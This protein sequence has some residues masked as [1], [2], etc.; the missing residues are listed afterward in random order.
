[1]P[2]H[3]QIARQLIGNLPPGVFGR[4]AR[5]A[6]IHQDFTTLNSMLPEVGFTAVQVAP[7]EWAL[8]ATCGDGSVVTWQVGA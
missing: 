6:V 4:A 3:A 2:T 1:M 5:D 8:V 7:D